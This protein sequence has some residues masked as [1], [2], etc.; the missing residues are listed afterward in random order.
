MVISPGSRGSGRDKSGPC[1][2]GEL[3]LEVSDDRVVVS[4]AVYIS[5]SGDDAPTQV[6]STSLRGE[7]HFFW[8]GLLAFN[9]RDEWSIN[10]QIGRL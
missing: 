10:W 4:P 7:H 3:G 2:G 9:L 8:L 1:S 5:R 6:D